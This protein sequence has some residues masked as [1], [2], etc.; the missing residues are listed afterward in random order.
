MGF[1]TAAASPMTENE[2]GNWRSLR[3]GAMLI[4]RHAQ[5]ESNAEARW[6]GNKDEEISAVGRRDTI[7]ACERLRAAVDDSVSLVISSSLRRALETAEILAAAVG[8][9]NIVQDS[10]LRERDMGEWTGMTPSEVDV[11]WPGLIAAWEAGEIE[12][13]PG[14][15]K[16]TEV[17][18][19]ARE[20]LWQ[21]AIGQPVPILVITHGGVLRSLRREAGLKGR[22]I[23]HL[24]GHWARID[25]ATKQLTI[26]APVLLGDPKM[27]PL[28]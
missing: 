4:I 3:N 2:F 9:K 13:P 22:A 1:Y 28:T 5:T 18:A 14:G 17:A 8:A 20:S 11:L 16:D 15:E 23:P 10:R 12:G 6:H 26:G 24:G 7:V 21:H 27:R 19:R 25:L